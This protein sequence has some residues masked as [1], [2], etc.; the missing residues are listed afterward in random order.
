MTKYPCT[1]EGAKQFEALSASLKKNAEDV[2]HTIKKLN[3]RMRI[4]EA[5]DEEYI[6]QAK[7]IIKESNS[8]AKNAAGQVQDLSKKLDKLSQ[9]ILKIVGNGIGGEE[10]HFSSTYTLKP[11]TTYTANGYTYQTDEKGRITSA[12]GTLR[13]ED[14]KRNTAHQ[15]AAGGEY[16]LS[17]DEGGHLIATIFG[18]SGKVDNIV[19]MDS[20][21]NRVTY[22]KMEK[23][24]QDELNRNNQ[25]D[26]KI[27][28]IY[29]GDSERPT[30]FLVKYRIRRPDGSVFQRIV[31]R[32]D[33]TGGS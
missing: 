8:Y 21:L 22:R 7:E 17:T 19:A 5:Y 14:G 29:E 25:V 18:G 11:S 15:I 28:L 16:R 31:K 2:I 4:L 24:W 6:K 33:N 23:Q 10:S 32:F 26:V 27:R 1:R 30:S 20:E 12:E 3:T 9:T 13:L